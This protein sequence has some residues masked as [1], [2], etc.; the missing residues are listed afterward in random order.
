MKMYP[1]RTFDGELSYITSATGNLLI[2]AFGRDDLKPHILDETA[3]F[4]AR[5]YGLSVKTANELKQMIPNPVELS[6]DSFPVSGVYYRIFNAKYP[7]QR[8][9][10]VGPRGNEIFSCHEAETYKSEFR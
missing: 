5:Q 1:F 7:G 6:E 8:L 3:T 2:G 9:I 4:L 10:K